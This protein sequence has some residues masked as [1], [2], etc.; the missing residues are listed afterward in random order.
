MLSAPR[1]IGLSSALKSLALMTRSFGTVSRTS[2]CVGAIGLFIEGMPS[3]PGRSV[4]EWSAAG[5]GR[6]WYSICS[7]ERGRTD[8]TQNRIE[9]DHSGGD[10]KIAFDPRRLHFARQ[11]QI[12]VDPDVAHL[13]VDDFEIVGFH[14]DGQTAQLEFVDGQIASDQERLALVIQNPDFVDVDAIGLEIDFAVEISVR[15]AVRRE[16]ERRFLNGNGAVGMRIGGRADHMHMGFECSGHV[17]QRRGEALHEAGINRRAVDKEIDR[18]ARAQTGAA[19]ERSRHLSFDVDPGGRILPE[20]RIERY[21]LAAV[22]DGAAEGLVLELLETAFLDGKL[23]TRLQSLWCA[24]D[25]ARRVEPA[26]SWGG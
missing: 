5:S 14:R 3:R 7:V 11:A 1:L 19:E 25:S 12:A 24:R 18:L 15:N 21:R 23:S 16:R 10:R 22:V 20:L 4:S 2:I 17:R 6:A 13:I 8:E 26:D 9:I